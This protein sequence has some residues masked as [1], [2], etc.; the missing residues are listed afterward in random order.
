MADNS[1]QQDNPK[2]LPE[3]LSAYLDGEVTGKERAVVEQA[4]AESPELRQE[5]E[6]LRRT[7]ALVKALPSTSAPRP[8][9]L[10]E[11]DVQ[12]TPAPRRSLRL[13]NW[14]GGLALFATALVCVLIAGGVLLTSQF[15]PRVS[16]PAEVAQAPQEAASQAVEAEAEQDLDGPVEQAQEEAAEVPP[17][18][19][20]DAAKEVAP[21]AAVDATAEGN[22]LAAETEAEMVGEAGD[23]SDLASQPETTESADAAQR[24]A[25]GAIAESGEVE[26]GAAQLTGRPTPLPAAT[27]TLGP[28]P[29]PT[30]RASAA[31]VDNFA[32]GEAAAEAEDAVSAEPAPAAEAAAEAMAEDK[33]TAAEEP[34]AAQPAAPG[35]EMRDDQSQGSRQE[36]AR[37]VEIRDLNVQVQPSLIQIDGFI[38]APA[39]TSLEASLQRDQGPFDSWAE[40]ASLQSVVGSDGRFTFSIRAATGRIDTDLF[41]IEPATYQI[42]IVSTGAD[43]PI[44]ATVV[45]DT[46]TDPATA[47]PAA[48][49]PTPPP[50]PTAGPTSTLSPT[51]VPQL[52]PTPLTIAT[53]VPFSGTGSQSTFFGLILGAALILIVVI[54]S[55][56]GLIIWFNIYKKR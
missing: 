17:Q 28:Q 56:V 33:L 40:P 14:A 31:G 32:G 55:M 21:A 44:M 52:T 49:S 15:N 30:T 48:T 11:A 42:S 9:T 1:N 23:G 43:V 46:T 4:L 50:S 51:A 53:A 5:L 6:S 22:E 24:E 18:P 19:A 34:A 10:S 25:G 3:L 2:N 37:S 41:A 12:A 36:E 13:P 27:A 39:G 26:S 29:S 54:L 38:E 16:A 7:V 45:F 8:F 35:P 20:Q 47:R